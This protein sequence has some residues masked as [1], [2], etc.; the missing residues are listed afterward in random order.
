MVHLNGQE[1][2]SAYSRD[3]K[4]AINS[5]S[6]SGLNRLLVE[7]AAASPGVEII[8]EA[9][10]VDADLTDHHRPAAIFEHA[11]GRQERIEA[12]LVIGTDG[13]F[14]AVRAAMQRTSRFDFSQTYLAAGYKELT[15]PPADHENGPHGRFRI[16]PNALHVWPHGGSMMIALPNID[17]SFT[18]TLFWPFDG[19]HSFATLEHA[20]DETV[21]AFFER[22]YGDAV[23]HMP[24]LLEDWNQNPTSPL[25]TIRCRPWH[26]GRAVLLGDA[27]H[28]IVPFYGQGANAS[29]ED[30]E[31]LVSALAAHP[32]DLDAAIDAYEASRIENA[33]AIADLALDQFIDMRDRSG[34]RT[35]RF[36]KKGSQFL[37]AVVP[38]WWTPLYDMVSFTRIPY[39]TALAKSRRQ[40]Q[41]LKTMASFL[42]PTF[43]IL[44]L[45]WFTILAQSST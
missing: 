20:D 27:A 22:H 15:I 40:A 38:F 29:F 30:V 34:S 35:Q 7:A 26:R 33:N 32:A 31:G 5:V 10:C 25:V 6:R 1:I 14:S 8:F 16:E 19:D 23:P 12:D 24:T 18:C 43:V 45:L 21:R 41:T 11:D 2:F 3:P 37:G 42:V 36:A 28:A 17:G 4:R 39:A 9:R 44:L 13:A